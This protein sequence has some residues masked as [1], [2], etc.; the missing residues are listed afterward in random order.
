M[1]RQRMRTPSVGSPAART[2]PQPGPAPCRCGSLQGCRAAPRCRAC[3]LWA[4][5]R[6][7]SAL[8]AANSSAS[9]RSMHRMLGLLHPHRQAQGRP[10]HPTGAQCCQPHPPP[11]RS[12]PPSLQ[13]PAGEPGG[14]GGSQRQQQQQQRRHVVSSATAGCTQHHCRLRRCHLRQCQGLAEQGPASLTV[15]PPWQRAP[16]RRA[17]WQRRLPPLDRWALMTASSSSLRQAQQKEIQYTR[18]AV[19]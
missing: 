19:G 11:S 1:Q 2:G 14:V 9:M 5:G 18:V 12:P 4:S 6:R 10:P 16:G 13:P 3:L 15:P 8:G 7:C 17:L